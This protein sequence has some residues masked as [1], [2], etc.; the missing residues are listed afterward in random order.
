MRAASA[1]EG[2]KNVPMSETQN[3]ELMKAY[4]D[5]AIYKEA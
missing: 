4:M 3:D 1:R 5:A 2:E